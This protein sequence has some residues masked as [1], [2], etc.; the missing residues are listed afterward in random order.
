VECGCG[1]QR[2]IRFAFRID[3]ANA[4]GEGGETVQATVPIDP[5]VRLSLRHRLTIDGLRPLGDDARHDPSGAKLR[6]ASRFAVDTLAGTPYLLAYAAVGGDPGRPRAVYGLAADPAH[7]AEDLDREIMRKQSLLPPSL[8]GAAGN[9]S[10][11][12][13]RVTTPRGIVVFEHG[14][15]FDDARAF[16]ASDTVDA[17][18]GGLVT[19]VA[20]R[21]EIAASLVIGGLPRS[22]LPMSL[23]LLGAAT[24]VSIMALAQFRRARE[25]ARLRSQFVANVSHELRTPLTQISM[26]SETLMLDRE[27]SPEE[28]RHFLS[29]IFREA[30]RLTNLV[31]GVLRF[32]RGEAGASRVRLERRDVS[33]DVRE[34]VQAF[35]P[36]AEAAETRLRLEIENDLE[37]WADF[38]AI[39]QVLLNLL[40]NAVKYGPSGQTVTVRATRTD[41]EVLVSVEDDGVGIPTAERQRVFE[42]FTRLEP[43]GAPRVSGSGIGL[44]VVRDLVQAHGGRVWIDVGAGGRGARVTFTLRH[45]PSGSES[46]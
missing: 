2:Q 40:D 17:A 23:A 30:R 24:L 5:G 4:D 42:P 16:S 9:D 13:V 31:D 18:L 32:S 29:V 8:V 7:L 25:L 26:F 1:F 43:A 41:A 10:V 39:R 33:A 21:P 28:G 46:L 3:L 22:R 45:A 35:S 34:A 27:R 37:A 14:R 15:P 12:N 19:T 36:L 11:V 44:A 20:L 6:E 38:A